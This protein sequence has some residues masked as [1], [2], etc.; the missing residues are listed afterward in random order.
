MFADQTDRNK[1]DAS[2]NKQ[3]SIAKVPTKFSSSIANSARFTRLLTDLISES[4]SKGDGQRNTST[5]DETRLRLSK[6]SL[7][8]SGVYRT[9]T[10]SIKCN[11][12]NAVFMSCVLF[13]EHSL[14]HGK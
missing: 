3:N 12:C 4:Q 1:F 7:G 6:M 13:A 5:A 11:I 8:H 10:K 9:P 14:L 2:G